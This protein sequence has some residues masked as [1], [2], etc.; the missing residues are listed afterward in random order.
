MEINKYLEA[1]LACLS[2]MGAPVFKWLGSVPPGAPEA[3]R[4]RIFLNSVG[5]IDWRMD[6]GVG[7][8]EQVPLRAVYGDWLPKEKPESSA[9]IIVGSGVGYGVNLVLGNTPNSHKLMVVEPR[10]EILLACLGQTDF[11]PFLE[12]GK[13][14]F[15][16]PD[17]EIIAEAVKHL[18]VAFIF[19]Q[20]Y[21]RPDYT[22][23]QLGP[24]YDL[25]SRITREKLE[26]FSVELATLRLKQETMV[27]NE[28]KNYSRAMLDGSLKPL[29]GMGEGATAVI[30]GAGPSLE[31]HAKDLIA[32]R[33][34]AIVCSALQT[35]PALERLGLKPDF[36]LAI[37][38]RHSMEN[39]MRGLSDVNFAKDIPL[40]YST[41]MQPGV[42]DLYPG[43]TIPLWTMGGLATFVMRDAEL[44]L[45]AG[46]NV[47]VTLARFLTWAG[48]RRFLLAGQDFAWKGEFS[49]AKGHHAA[50]GAYRFDP[51]K[52]VTLSNLYGE[53]IY[54]HMGF[55][56]AKRDLEADIKT[57][58]DAA[59][60]N[61]YG[62]G[63]VIEG[64]ENLAIAAVLERGLL[65]GGASARGRFLDALERARGPRMRPVYQARGNSWASSMRNVQ[66]K[67]EKFFKKPERYQAEIRATLA[68]VQFFLKQ[69]PLYLPYLYNEIMDL[70]GMVQ[71]RIK[72][73]SK[74][75]VEFRQLVR[76]INGKIKE[77]DTCL[78][79][80][81][82][83]AA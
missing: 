8:L 52:D 37:D 10:P 58:P 73:G 20:I 81:A 14:H 19:G 50:H 82:Q 16:P 21:L 38:F 44:V 17:Q 1:N 56:A 27:S 63:A 74:D 22:L 77:M 18:D 36:C 30:L 72:F 25:W 11:T 40:I 6:N 45:D 55:I 34:E 70:T 61:I 13:L 48:V 62:G 7:V 43:P 60:Y 71:T 39:A 53:Q 28:L 49:H 57:C 9:T 15:L 78:C 67:L 33:R 31:E 64:A 80:P 3:V 46:G 75:M 51:A 35:L 41:K 47:G 65:I 69:D 26:N 59:Y 4:E 54:S 66:K 12:A 79:A 29:H 83:A 2:R 23:R 42:L 68:Q 5:L 24:E 32:N 76:R